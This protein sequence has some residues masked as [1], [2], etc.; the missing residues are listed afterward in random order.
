[1]KLVHAIISL[2]TGGAEGMLA[3]LVQES[4]KNPQIKQSIIT[5]KG[6][7]SIGHQ[8]RMK[9]FDVISLDM[10]SFLNFPIAIYKLIKLFKVLRPNA[11][12][13]WMYHADLLCGV[14]AYLSGVKNIIWGIRNTEIPQKSFSITFAVVKICSKLSFYI[15]NKIVCCAE[16]AKLA[17]T[18]LGFCSS[19]M[20]VVPNGYDLS[21]FNPSSN[22]RG[23]IRS[24]LGFDEN[25]LVVGIV[26][27]YDPLKDFKNFINAASLVSKDFDNVKFLMVGRGL[28]YSNIELCSWIANCN[29]PKSF[30]LMG[31][32]TPHELYAAMDVYCLS[33]KAEGFPNVVAEAMSMCIPCV[34]TNVGDASRIVEDS[35]IVVK[36]KDHFALY[37]G[38]SYILAMDK[39]NRESLGTQARE[40]IKSKYD[41]KKIQQ[42]FL[43]LVI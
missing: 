34:V 9:G 28:D 12:F 7:G 22:L 37:K 5:L 16:S 41:I 1:M 11:I 36:S 39:N 33:S 21:L 42:N 8:L 40:L 26:G 27:R 4:S 43:D 25:H 31:E 30:I 3:R 13:T 14:A 32:A 19:K 6:E 35:G 15:P 38:L 17:H 23:R 20:V 10:K 24:D 18:K 29:D 2:E